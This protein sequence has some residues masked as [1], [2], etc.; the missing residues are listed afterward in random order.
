MSTEFVGWDSDESD[1]SETDLSFRGRHGRGAHI[2]RRSVSRPRPPPR[3]YQEYRE[4]LYPP[5]ETRVYRSAST[6]GR[7][8]RD[9]GPSVTI[10]N[11]QAADA[12]AVNKPRHRTEQKLIDAESEEDY[13][14]ARD[15]SSRR[16]TTSNLNLNVERTPSPYHRDYELMMNQRLLDRN[17]VRQDLEIWKAQ[18]EIE[19]LERE[20]ERRREKPRPVEAPPAPP[21]PPAMPGAPLVPVIPARES[22]LLREEEEWYEDEISERLRR[23]ERYERKS[24]EE[25][26]QRKS[27]RAWRLKKLEEA[28]KEAAEK[29]ELKER[30]K[31]EKIKEMERQQA[32]EAERNKIKQQLIEEERRRALAAEEARKAQLAMKAAAVEEW[33]L[34]QERIKQAEKEAAIRKDKEFR[35]RL[36]IEFG[37]SEKEIEHILNKKEREEREAKEKKEKEEKEAKEKKEKEEKEKKEKEEKERKEKEERE[38][39]EKE[40]TTWI[41]VHRK[42]LLPETL[43]AYNL[44]WEWDERDSNYIIIK[45]WITE[46]FQEELFSHT[47]RLR[48]G[49]VIAQTSSSTTELKINDRN[50]DKMYLVRKKSPSRRLR[51]FA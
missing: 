9:V 7:R 31:Q 14:I 30:I 24:K 34:E 8:Q 41:K 28:E 10:I 4:T 27:E 37:Y 26:L 47:R 16:R 20:L 36:R 22:R 29:E 42:H 17:D 21:A 43:I 1:F 46:D 32:E 6:G 45:R 19:R 48:E 13:P 25:E 44:P 3:E 18:Q 11:K 38:R 39:V 50:K 5:R 40:K 51:I 12:R 35:E 49:K 33:K 23:L 15:R 2:R